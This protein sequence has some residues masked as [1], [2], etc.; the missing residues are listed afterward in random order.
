[1]DQLIGHKAKLEVTGLL[2]EA[3]DQALTQAEAEASSHKGG[4]VAL[5]EIALSISKL[6]DRVRQERDEGK[7]DAEEVAEAVQR[8]LRYAVECCLNLAEKRK[9]EEMIANGKAAA[10][11]ASVAVAQSHHNAS[12][13]RIEQ[14]ACP[15]TVEDTEPE[16]KAKK[17][18][19]GRRPGEH[20]GPS[21][22]D[23]RR[24]KG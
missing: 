5:R 9:A 6:G 21:P 13:R 16:A 3:F 18:R 22:L 8:Y 4:S 1:M 10:F 2:G 23:R 20:P 17:R 12:A 24:A 15:P 14:L 7:L 11:R 19:R